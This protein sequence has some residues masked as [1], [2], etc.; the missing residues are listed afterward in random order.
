MYVLAKARAAKDGV[1]VAMEGDGAKSRWAPLR[2]VMPPQAK[3][4]LLQL[5]GHLAPALCHVGQDGIDAPLVLAHVVDEGAISSRK[6]VPYPVH[7]F[8]GELLAQSTGAFDPLT[9]WSR[10]H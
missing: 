4:V 1:E 6:P 10:H 5:V 8:L 7:A 3:I 2:T 9:I